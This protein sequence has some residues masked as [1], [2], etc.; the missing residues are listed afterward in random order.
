M[1][2]LD[3]TRLGPGDLLRIA[4]GADRPA[5]D[6]AA[7]RLVARGRAVVDRAVTEGRPI[8]GVTT[9]VGAQKDHRVD[10]DEIPRF[11]RRLLLAHATGTG[12]RLLSPAETRAV[13]TVQLNLFAT[14]RSGVRPELVR[15]LQHWFDG[16]H[17]PAA[18]L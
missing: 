8:Y 7:F 12:G 17:L 1:L 3:G 4:E 11:N 16:P 18:E 14:G 15:A 13:L 6:E 2:L 10:S 9:G 5:L